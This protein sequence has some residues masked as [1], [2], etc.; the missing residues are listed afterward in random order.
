M[1]PDC[2]VC[3]AW[4]QFGSQ[5]DFRM[6]GLPIVKLGCSDLTERLHRRNIGVGEDSAWKNRQGNEAFVISTLCWA[7]SHKVKPWILGPEN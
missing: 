6:S 1:G 3:V 7:P 2:T 5:T 4:I